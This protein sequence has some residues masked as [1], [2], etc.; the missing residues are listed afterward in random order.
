MSSVESVHSFRF[1]KV[2]LTP[3][4][5]R[6][7]PGCL[8]IPWDICVLDRF[9][10]SG[11]GKWLWLSV[12]SSCDISRQGATSS[13]EK[14]NPIGEDDWPSA[15]HFLHSSDPL[16]VAIAQ[17][18]LDCDI[19]KVILAGSPS[20]GSWLG[21]PLKHDLHFTFA[22]NHEDYLVGMI[23]LNL[24]EFMSD[25]WKLSDEY[26]LGIDECPY[27]EEEDEYEFIYRTRGSGGI[28]EVRCRRYK[29][30]WIFSFGLPR[31]PEWRHGSGLTLEEAFLSLREKLP[32]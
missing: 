9:Q 7:E 5:E 28:W 13:P 14:F 4:F 11:K 22:L 27:Q 10:D 12:P 3:M 29:P 18:L 15:D 23:P 2:Q 26:D 32:A 25:V 16:W 19:E 31:D 24:D 17:K 21:H 30:L 20:P 8:L 6:V 1:S